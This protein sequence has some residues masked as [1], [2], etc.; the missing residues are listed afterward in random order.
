MA[1]IELHL[2]VNGVK[3]TLQVEPCG[4]LLELLRDK[5]GLTGTKEACG[6]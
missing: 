4:T 1:E 6:A 5:L 2:T 3:R